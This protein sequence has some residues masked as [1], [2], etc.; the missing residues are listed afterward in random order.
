MEGG[1]GNKR[2]GK[3]K[4]GWRGERKVGCKNEG[5]ERRTD[6]RSSSL[7]RGG[8]GGRAAA[9]RPDVGKAERMGGRVKW[10]RGGGRVG[11]GWQEVA[12]GGRRGGEGTGGEGDQR[13]STIVEEGQE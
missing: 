13:A 10:V 2:R 6:D 7:E 8:E 11:G 9:E 1:G 5:R 12:P 4:V 3:T